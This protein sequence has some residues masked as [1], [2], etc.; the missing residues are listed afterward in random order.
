MQSNRVGALLPDNFG[1]FSIVNVK[2]AS[3]GTTGNAAVVLPVQAGSSYIVRQV[4]IANA[5]GSINTANVVILTSSDGNASNAITAVSVLSNITSTSTYQDLSLA[6][7][8]AT[9]VYTAQAL[10]LKVNTA[11]ANATCDI[12][13]YGDIV[14]P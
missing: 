13:V 11:V 2:A 5:S 8:T 14:T 4:T 3:V 1:S 7:G 10:F 9:T 6:A 12:Q